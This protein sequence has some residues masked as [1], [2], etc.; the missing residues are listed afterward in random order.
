[1]KSSSRIRLRKSSS[2]VT[3]F[4]AVGAYSGEQALQIVHRFSPDC[5]LADVLMPFMN[6]SDLAITIRKISAATR[7]VLFSGHANWPHLLNDARLRGH[8]FE[9]VGEPIH[10]EKLMQLLRESP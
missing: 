8:Q 10:P 2:S 7:I 4:N 1:M 6:G 9:V 3:V 5:L